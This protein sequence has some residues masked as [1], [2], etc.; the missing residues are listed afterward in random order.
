MCHGNLSSLHRFFDD[1]LDNLLGF[2]DRPDHSYRNAT[3]G[4][5]I[6]ARRAGI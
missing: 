5:T 1:V 3:T 4:S 6:V 2:L